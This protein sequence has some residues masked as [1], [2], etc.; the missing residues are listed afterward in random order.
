[1]YGM[2]G[3]RCSISVGSR[4]HCKCYH[5]VGTKFDNSTFNKNTRRKMRHAK[6]FL[7]WYTL[8]TTN[9]PPHIDLWRQ[10]RRWGSEYKES[11]SDTYLTIYPTCPIQPRKKDNWSYQGCSRWRKPFIWVHM[12]G[13]VEPLITHTPSVAGGGHGLW[14]SMDFREVDRNRYQKFHKT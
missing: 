9:F 1:M 11:E 7:I 8:G 10:E 4:R 12:A 3:E 6:V 5:N 2:L 13:T 14:E